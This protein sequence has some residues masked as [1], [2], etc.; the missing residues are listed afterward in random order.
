MTT[1][2]YP[3]VSLTFSPDKAVS[4]MRLA[5]GCWGPPGPGARGWAGRMRL[6]DR[7]PV[8]ADTW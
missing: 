5:S 1:S 2:S 4:R 6:G 7:R 3:Q 8:G